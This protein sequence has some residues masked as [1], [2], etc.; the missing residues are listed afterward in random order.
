MCILNHRD[1]QFYLTMFFLSVIPQESCRKKEITLGIS[2][3]FKIAK[4]F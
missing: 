1:A 3:V 2:Q 4:C